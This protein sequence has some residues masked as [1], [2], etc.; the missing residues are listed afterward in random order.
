MS[1]G[2]T[3]LQEKPEGGSSNRPIT[4][5]MCR[6]ATI[7]LGLLAALLPLAPPGLEN[8]A[9]QESDARHAVEA[10]TQAAPPAPML[11]SLRRLL[12][13]FDFE[14]AKDAPHEMPINFYRHI[15]T[16]GGFPPFGR[17]RLTDDAAFRG[18]WSF[19]FELVEGSLSARVPTAVL[20]ILPM[21]DYVITARVRTLGLT[22]ARARLV[23]WLH[24]TRGRIIPESRAEGELRRTDG[25][26]EV[27]SLHVYGDFEEAADLVLELQLLQP[28]QFRTDPGDL[29]RPLVEDVEG[30][31]WFDDVSVWH[32]PRIELSTDSPSSLLT[33]L[34][35]PRLLVLVRDLTNDRLTARL[36][37]LNLD[38][39][40][41]FDQAFPAPRGREPVRVE[42]PITHYGWYR[43][44]L[45]VQ[46]DLE[47]VGRRHLDF[48]VVAP[49]RRGVEPSDNPFAVVI[50]P[51]PLER[52][53][54]VADVIEHL[55]VGSAVV[56]AWDRSL[57]IENARE[58]HAAF[59]PVI[60]RLLDR[61]IGLTLALDEVPDELVRTHGLAP[62]AVLDLLGGD[63]KTWRP[64]LG[65]TLMSF[66]LQ[67]RRWQIG[68]TGSTNAFWREDLPPLL[69]AARR[70]LGKFVAD[71]T[72][73]VSLSAEQVAAGTLQLPG[74]HITMPH[75]VQPE[76]IGA[77]ASDWPLEQRE[78]LTSFDLLPLD[79]YTP[80]QQVTD[81]VLRA[82]YGWRAGL[83]QLAIEAPWSF[84]GPQET[85][86]VPDPAFAVWRVLADQ[87][88]QRRFVGE[89][90]LAD[91]VRCWMLEGRRPG[92]AALVAWNERF[93][94]EASI[95]VAALLAAGP[96]QIVD[97][98]GNRRRLDPQDGVHTFSVGPVPVFIEKVNLALARFRAG[99]RIDPSF[100]PS[101]QKVHECEIVLRNPWDVVIWGTIRLV[102]ND[103]WRMTPRL[104]RFDIRPRR[105][106]RLP[107][108]L[109]IERSLLAGRMRVEA[110]VDLLADRAYHLKVHTDLEVGLRD[111]E[112]Q[113]S[114]SVAHNPRTGVDD[115][116][117]TQSVT[118]NTAEV[119][120][121][122]VYL[123]GEGVGR[124]SRAIPPLAP[125][126]TAVR[127][128]R[129][130]DGAA[131]L[132]GKQLRIG[133]SERNGSGQLNRAIKIPDLKEEVTGVTE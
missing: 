124:K 16:D 2:S 44:V 6:A 9:S 94:G 110:Q 111:I 91:G 122:N 57:T 62:G 39:Q 34:D 98:F 104:H 19:G 119:V 3:D 127:S 10:E 77:Y 117:V 70:S 52:L 65:E 51:T 118:N 76:A 26:W 128:F 24:D 46:S 103:H 40:P 68:A 28:R 130:P 89:L 92:D 106:V 32:V 126:E 96:V 95:E 50:P 88:S 1:A 12:R 37:V 55:E 112:L 21:S 115:L 35:P 120:H 83:P 71:P 18:D 54:A 11:A 64:Y 114:W 20:P 31:V 22:H 25:V 97:I 107:V 123:L 5:A 49:P 113:A 61:G 75:H 72:I 23:A 43:A 42:V 133:I 105:E 99:F 13:R 33:T 60:E 45:D 48:V 84:G 47:P 86:L 29:H 63:P 80:R 67:V 14:E 15:A 27:A 41:V 69:E 129:L 109:V 73:L 36:R 100:I 58:W 30:R 131:K 125:G 79:Q 101:Q 93:T 78:I 7:P 102:P 90:P 121:L 8:G 38:G 81:L 4:T 116:I 132:A 85:R 74:Y 56:P 53:G 82:L 87:L 17:M 66:G 108:D 59:D